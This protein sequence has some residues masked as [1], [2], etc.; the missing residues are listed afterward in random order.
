MINT[1]PIYNM[2]PT[3]KD[4]INA[5]QVLKQIIHPNSFKKNVIKKL[6]LTDLFIY[7]YSI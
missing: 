2:L 1:S 5:N 4:I 6:L 7:K 3:S